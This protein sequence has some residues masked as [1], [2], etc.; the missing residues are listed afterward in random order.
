MK[1]VLS[2]QQMPMRSPLI[3][4]M[5]TWL[6]LDR[7]DAVGWVYGVVGTMVVILWIAFFCSLWTFTPTKIRE[8]E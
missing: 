3:L 7:F 1:K 2:W 4:S 8:L 5:V 6:M